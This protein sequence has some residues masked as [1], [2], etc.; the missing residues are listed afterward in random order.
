MEVKHEK[1]NK[2]FVAKIDNNEAELSYRILDDGTLDYHR[3]YVPENLRGQGIAQKVTE[4]ALNFAKDQNKK[5]KPSCP[6]V[7]KYIEKNQHYQDL[8][9]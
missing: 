7:E 9:A 5:V 6:F 2:R 4:E 3:T 8:L 1:S